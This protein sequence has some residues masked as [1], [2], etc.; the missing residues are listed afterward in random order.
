M[1]TKSKNGTSP[2]APTDPT[3][4]A[5]AG[6][7]MPA[8]AASVAGTSAT[9][10]SSNTNTGSNA[11]TSSGNTNTRNDPSLS[12]LEPKYPSAAAGDGMP[13]AAADYAGVNVPG[14]KNAGD[15]STIGG[16]NTGTTGVSSAKKEQLRQEIGQ[17]RSELDV[18]VSHAATLSE[19]ELG[20]AYQMLMA[21]FQTYRTKAMDLANNAN[22]QLNQRMEVTRGQVKE[23]PVQSV[24]IAAGAGMLMGLMMGGKRRR[25]DQDR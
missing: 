3:A 5:A 19:R 7:G 2:Q 1:N 8:G 4:P 16:A 10:G 18:L 6:N 13:A 17:L 23:K 11:T 15:S 21:R 9:A 24:A 12:S 25:R 20:E 14:S 22:Q